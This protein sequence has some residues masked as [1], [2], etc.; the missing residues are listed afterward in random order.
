MGSVHRVRMIVGERRAGAEVHSIG[1]QHQVPVPVPVAVG[2]S[3]CLAVDPDVG[4]ERY[5]PGRWHLGGEK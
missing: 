5:R 2:V 1:D 3:L 4:R